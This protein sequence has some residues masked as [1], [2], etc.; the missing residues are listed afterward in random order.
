MRLKT[1]LWP[2]YRS[3]RIL[4]A[5]SAFAIVGINLLVSGYP[6]PNA[7]G[8]PWPTYL[9]GSNLR[10][11]SHFFP[12]NLFA[13]ALLWAVILISVGMLNQYRIFRNIPL[14]FSLRTLILFSLSLCWNLDSFEY[15]IP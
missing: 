2:V 4:L 1:L 11:L 12:P 15:S 6:D 9:R 13:N 10:G 8:F 5:I 7:F 3:T 14:R